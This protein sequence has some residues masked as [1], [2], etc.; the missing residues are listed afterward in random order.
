MDEKIAFLI[1]G[2]SLGILTSITVKAIN[3][4][5]IKKWYKDDLKRKRKK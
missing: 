2:Y 1:L 4:W 3:W 5:K